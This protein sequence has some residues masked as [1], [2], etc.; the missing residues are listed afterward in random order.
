MVVNEDH[1][2]YAV[3]SQSY[4]TL[5]DDRMSKDMST[6]PSQQTGAG[7]ASES[8]PLHMETYI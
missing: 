6:V 5:V 7:R 8:H 3:G 4:I 2:I 1:G